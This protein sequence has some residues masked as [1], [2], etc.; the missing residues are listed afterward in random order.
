M[1]RYLGI[2]GPSLVMSL[3]E[4]A[5]V[6]II[7]RKA[8]NLKTISFKNVFVSLDRTPRQIE[9]YKIISGCAEG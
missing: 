1:T 8:E 7:V 5:Q 3:H 9:Y 4:E 6:M 2:D